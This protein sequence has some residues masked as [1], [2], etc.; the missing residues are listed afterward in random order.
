MSAFPGFNANLLTR[1]WPISV[2]ISLI[3]LKSRH[4]S[5]GVQVN[6]VLLSSN[7]DQDCMEICC[8]RNYVANGKV[9]SFETLLFQMS[10]QVGALAWLMWLS[11]AR[12]DFRIVE[13]WDVCIMILMTTEM[14]KEME[15]LNQAIF[16]L[17]FLMIKLK[18]VKVWEPFISQFQKGQN[19]YPD[20]HPLHSWHV[21]KGIREHQ[22]SSENWILRKADFAVALGP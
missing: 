19:H 20:T 14:V 15:G 10:H 18:E 8:F 7:N 12:M 6:T 3:N 1:I 17:V 16:H 5:L 4:I 11:K 22:N 21:R 9:R 13:T 2:N